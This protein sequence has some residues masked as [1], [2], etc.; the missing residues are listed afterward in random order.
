MQKIIFSTILT[1]FLATAVAPPGFAQMSQGDMPFLPEAGAMVPLSA[2][3]EPARMVGLELD[4]KNPFKLNFIIDQGPKPL[5]DEIRKQEFQKLINYFLVSLTVPNNDMWVN[6]SPYEQNRIIPNDFSKTAMGRDLLAEDYI[7]KQITASTIYPEGRIGKE[8]WAQVYHQAAKEFGTTNVPVNTYNKVWIVPD[9]AVIYEKNGTALLMES[10]L[11]VM[12]EEDYLSLTK[13]TAISNSVIPDSTPTIGSQVIRKIVIPLLEKEVNEGKNFAPLRQAYSAML[14]ATYFKRA[15]RQ[16]ILGQIYADK[17]KVLGVD[18]KDSNAQKEKI[19]QQYLKAYKKGVFNYIK[20]DVDTISQ[21]IIPRKYFSGGVVG[22]NESSLAMVGEPTP[23]GKRLW[24][25]FLNPAQTVPRIVSTSVVLIPVDQAMK[26]NAT[27]MKEAIFWAKLLLGEFNRKPEGVDDW[28]FRVFSG[29]VP[30]R[31]LSDVRK[32]LDRGDWEEAKKIFAAREVH[33][34][35]YS[36]AKY[37]Q[38][39]G[40]SRFKTMYEI[41]QAL[42]N[43]FSTALTDTEL[44]SVRTFI[45]KKVSKSVQEKLKKEFE[46]TSSIEFNS[47]T[48]ENERTKIKNQLLHQ[49]ETLLSELTKDKDYVLLPNVVSC[50]T[51][52]DEVHTGYVGTE[53]GPVGSYV[54]KVHFNFDFA[55]KTSGIAAAALALLPAYGTSQVYE[56]TQAWQYETGDI[57]YQHGG[58]RYSID[59][60]NWTLAIYGNDGRGHEKIYSAF[61]S[62]KIPQYVIDGI[63]LFSE[64]IKNSKDRHVIRNR[65]REQKT[66][67]DF[68]LMSHRKPRANLHAKPKQKPQRIGIDAAM[69]TNPKLQDL[70]QIMNELDPE[71]IQRRLREIFPQAGIQLNG[72]YLYLNRS[73]VPNPDELI[74]QLLEHLP[75]VKHRLVRIMDFNTSQI[76]S[77]AA[78]NIVTEDTDSQ[79]RDTPRRLTPSQQ[80]ILF[81]SFDRREGNIFHLD[82]HYD[83]P[84]LATTSTTPILL[85]YLKWLH[86]KPYGSKKIKELQGSFAI[87]DHS[88]ADILLANYLIT[89]AGDLRFL[90][91]YGDVLAQGAN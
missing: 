40:D 88:D 69:N 45:R 35:R 66:L 79:I 57:A 11:K 1:A 62:N 46:G 51:V 44:E 12:L 24:Q 15:L 82:H 50:I 52:F 32:A 65:D 27:D 9:K 38:I 4:P 85:D 61:A 67:T 90:D 43:H 53:M 76:P 81:S 71:E 26:S 31:Q 18:L 75:Q 6:L 89:K 87:M 56:D 7:L 30:K 8:F 17:D 47:L 64:S 28:T 63:G 74:S 37:A 10:H 68:L 13:H 34:W 33:Q 16:S 58:I 36:L 19:Y 3:N 84:A 78:N 21:Q 55:M 86:R 2:Y 54:F 49:I 83:Y 29:Q 73:A 20:E 5:S 22:F 72:N 70:F 25:G 42:S 23:E 77:L 48:G 39:G 80:E 60:K 41:Y 91:T 59:T 14:M